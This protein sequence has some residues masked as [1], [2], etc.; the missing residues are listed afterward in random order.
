MATAFARDVQH[1]DSSLTR[2]Y[3]NLSPV[4]FS[5]SVVQQAPQALRVITAPA[6]GWNDLGTP[7]RVADTLRRLAQ[8][9][10]PMHSRPVA[11]RG[12]AASGLIN[13]ATQQARVALTG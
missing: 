9:R 12:A 4:D 2:L 6:C 8:L 10:P 7:R 11:A 5:R 1:G 3:E 13:L